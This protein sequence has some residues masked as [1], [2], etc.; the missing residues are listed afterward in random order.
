MTYKMNWLGLKGTVRSQARDWEATCELLEE[1]E[2]FCR[3][4][5]IDC[6]DHSFEREF[7]KVG[8]LE[9]AHEWCASKMKEYDDE[10]IEKGTT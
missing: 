5:K 7:F 10:R 3:T 2:W 9:Q 1:R 8:E 6:W 4:E